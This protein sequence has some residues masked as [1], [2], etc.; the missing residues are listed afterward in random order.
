MAD[1]KKIF[2]VELSDKFVTRLMSYFHRNLNVSL[3][4]LVKYKRSTIAKTVYAMQFVLSVWYVECC[5]Y[6][7]LQSMCALDVFHTMSCI[8]F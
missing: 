6:G 2:T 5:L 4:Y 1:F 3:Y 7:I 8:R